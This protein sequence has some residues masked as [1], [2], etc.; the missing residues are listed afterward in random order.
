MDKFVKK[1]V[2][3]EFFKENNY[4]FKEDNSSI[5]ITKNQF[6][7]ILRFIIFNFIGVI[8]LIGAVLND[9]NL[10]MI[11]AGFMFGGIGLLLDRK[12]YPF[13]IRFDKSAETVALKHGLTYQRSMTFSEISSLL[14]D[15]SVL[16]GDTSPFKEGYQDF[17][18]SFFLQT[19]KQKIKLIRFSFRKESSAQIQP[20]FEHLSLALKLK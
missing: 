17:N 5:E 20:L 12:G 15:E 14:V 1:P 9:F 16:H 10:S 18:Y 3:A 2:I 8:L 7:R 13:Q 11:L 4:C 6:G 19:P